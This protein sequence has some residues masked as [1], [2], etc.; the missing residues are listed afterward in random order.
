[1]QTTAV[2]AVYEHGFLKPQRK[3]PIREHA[4]VTL[5]VQPS[6]PVSRTRKQFSVSKRLAKVLIYDDS[7]QE[8]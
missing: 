8:A 4:K 6:D 3:L 7:L 1:M 2:E 5:I